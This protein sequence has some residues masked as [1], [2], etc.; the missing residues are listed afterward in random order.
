VFAH[1]RVTA[2]T[3]MAVRNVLIVR[4]VSARTAILKILIAL[5]RNQRV[6]VIAVPVH[7]HRKA[8]YAK[9]IF[10]ITTNAKLRYY[11]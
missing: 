2:L 1:K 11:A 7:L 4:S 8:N 6:V 10:T 3:V 5:V 9:I